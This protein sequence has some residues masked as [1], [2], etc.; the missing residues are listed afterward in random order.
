MLHSPYTVTYIESFYSCLHNL[1][2][3]RNSN[4]HVSLADKKDSHNITHRK[5][6][7]DNLLTDGVSDLFLI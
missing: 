2:R 7:N 3:L 5:W 1:L 6:R 4:E